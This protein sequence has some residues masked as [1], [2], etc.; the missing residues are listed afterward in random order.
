MP[1]FF[2]LKMIVQEQMRRKAPGVLMLLNHYSRQRFGV[3]F[4]E[5][6]FAMPR[7][8]FEMIKDVYEGEVTARVVMKR[9]VMK[10]IAEALG[11]PDLVDELMNVAL[12]GCESFVT[13]LRG[14]GVRGVGPEICRD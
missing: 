3:K 12:D 6:V 7:K 4:V 10:P 11:N 5:A 2:E 9:L 13:F 14:H 8:V 1:P